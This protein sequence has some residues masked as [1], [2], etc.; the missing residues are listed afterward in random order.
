MLNCW[1]RCI[2]NIGLWRFCNSVTT[3]LSPT[4]MVSRVVHQ[5][6]LI[7]ICAAL[8][9]RLGRTESQS[10]YMDIADI[11]HHRQHWQWC[12]FFKHVPFFCTGNAYWP[13]WA[14]WL[15]IYALMVYSYRAK[16][17]VYHVWTWKFFLHPSI[18]FSAGKALCFLYFLWKRNSNIMLLASPCIVLPNYFNGKEWG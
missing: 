2:G 18:D 7:K 13:I 12:T 10:W 11:C 17:Y 3:T 5:F 1:C 4:K 8:L 14:V 6:H 9:Y 16:W 15:Q